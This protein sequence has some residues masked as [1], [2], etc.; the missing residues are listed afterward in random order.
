MVSSP[1]NIVEVPA[2]EI[3]FLEQQ[4]CVLVMGILEIKYYFVWLK[5]EDLVW[6]PKPLGRFYKIT[7]FIVSLHFN[8]N[9]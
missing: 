2:P 4:A 6:F 8:F 7:K 3:V 9:L 1:D 5:P